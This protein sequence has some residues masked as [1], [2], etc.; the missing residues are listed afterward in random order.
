MYTYLQALSKSVIY[1]YNDILFYVVPDY[2]SKCVML[3]FSFPVG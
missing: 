1:V 3:P 2:C